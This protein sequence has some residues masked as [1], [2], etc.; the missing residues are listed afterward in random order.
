MILSPEGGSL[1]IPFKLACYLITCGAE[2]YV[3]K[4][5]VLD[6][7]MVKSMQNLQRQPLGWIF[8]AAFPIKSDLYGEQQAQLDAW[9]KPIDMD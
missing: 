7:D 1:G 6:Y 3:L 8:K 9:K 4:F 5:L 2:L